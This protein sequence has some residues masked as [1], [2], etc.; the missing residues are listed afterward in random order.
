MII[1]LK[2]LRRLEI[3][4]RLR[5]KRGDAV[6]IVLED[7]EGKKESD[8]LHAMAVQ[9]VISKLNLKD[10]VETIR[11]TTGSKIQPEGSASAA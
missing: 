8:E 5:Q 3:V 4:R 1:G 7:A 2:S 10:V 9:A 6:C 11:A